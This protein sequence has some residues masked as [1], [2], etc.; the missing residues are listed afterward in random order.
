MQDGDLTRPLGP[1]KHMLSA[2][3]AGLITLVLTNPIFVVKTRLCLQFGPSPQ[4]LSE[5][6]KYKGIVDAL[7]KTY[8]YEGV[9]GLYKGFLPGVFGVSYSA[10]QFVTY[11]VRRSIN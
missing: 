10:L 8:E 1:T 2:A 3:Q 9:R 5:K 6:K 4:C 11:E 7:I